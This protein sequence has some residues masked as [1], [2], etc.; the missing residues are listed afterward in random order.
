[1]K[2][3]A[4]CMLLA[5]C[6]LLMH[7]IPLRAEQPPNIVFIISD[8]HAWT[9]YGFMGHPQIETPHLDALAK[10]SAVFTRGYVPTA[11]CRPAL[12][13][14]ITGK[15][16]HQH[17][18]SGNDPAIL[19][20]MR[21]P[22]AQGA[23]PAEYRE[24]RE[25]LIAQIDRQP[26]LPQLLSTRGYR[27]H[28]SGKWWEGNF[29]RGGFTD[30]MTRGFPEPGGRHGDDGLKIGRE[31]MEPVLD[32]IDRCVA[33]NQ[34]FF[35]WYAPFLPHSPHNPPPRLLAK[36]KAKGIESEHVARY[37]AMVE[38]FDETCGQLTEH[39]DAKG[40]REKT[41]IVYIGDNGWIQDP[42]SSG[43]A[44]RSK[45]SANEGGTRQ[46]TMFCWPSVIK[47]GD[48]QQQLCSSV[49]IVP[50]ALAAAGIDIPQE[51]P[52][53]NLL[54]ALKSGEPA[55]REQVF[56]ESFA[57]DIAD[58]DQPEA[59][60]LYRWVIDGKWKLL[61]TYD[62]KVGRYA[63]HHPLTE[64][65]PQLF[66]LL[67]D[68][69][70]DQ[71]LASAEPEVLARLAERLQAWWPV[72]ERKVQTTIASST[73]LNPQRPN[74]LFIA[75]DDQNDWV[76]HMGG[77]PLAHT[78]HIDQLAERGTTFLNAHCQ[79][80]L[81]NPSRTSLM[82]SLR[83]TTTGIY[84]LAP[85]FRS[86]DGWKDRVTLAQHFKRSGYRTLTAGKIFH[87]GVGDPAARRAE[88]DEWGPAGGIGV[89]P[90]QKLI[91]ATPMGN[92]PLMDWG[93]FPHR[94]EDK[95]DYQVASWAVEQI[96]S[97]DRGQPFFLAA[98]FF[99]PHVPCY[100]TQ[101][102]FDL[103]PDDDR[104]LPL[105]QLDDRN[106]TPR[107]SWY[108]HWH[109]PEPRLKWVQDNAQWRNLSRSYLAC[110]SFVDEQ[111]GRVLA[112]LDEAGLAD[113]T[114]VVLWSDHGFHLGEKGITGKN[115]LWED[116]TRVPLVF[117]GPGVSAQ[118]RCVQPAELLD[119]YPTLVELCGLPP[120]DDLEGI[121]LLPQL[122]DA[123]THRE[124]PAVTS[125]NQGNHGVRS[126]RWRYIR[127][128]DGSEELYDQQTDPHEWTNLIANPG[129]AEVV[130][131]HKRWLPVHDVEPAVGSAHRVLTYD[132][133]T[134]EAIWEG[135]AIR[136]DT[137]IP[138]D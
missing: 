91:P 122:Q 65:G 102:W 58:I 2:S 46:P 15:Y 5:V 136:R 44:A 128:A 38:W 78:P 135:Q 31:G 61:L 88:F 124:R 19:P 24:L 20:S 138:N 73:H 41:L 137:P 115:T 71:N 103:F 94:D 109:L 101:K 77:H 120:R 10:Q 40:I 97:A 79:A 83:P 62:G 70:E 68:P 39:L 133:T 69:H 55:P 105:I 6:G 29:R 36:Y 116:G 26:T 43:F 51:L 125:H 67:A 17:K 60:L 4:T 129:L 21:A 74:V 3:V 16:A 106:D 95:G 123:T 76:G 118:Q 12:A 27:S 30:G 45:Q 54:P 1:M 100:T 121:S 32:F 96:R 90:D 47:P 53:Y 52:G 111:V 18:I 82:L 59:S 9:D 99:L 64:K 81:C 107:F 72:T 8:D 85:W 48:R 86:L 113:N 80:P 37:Y 23:E 92:H 130:E 108:L 25:R 33:D 132:K 7:G 14:L 66:D 57:H 134:D 42:G 84:G 127:Y 112:A 35:T 93:V 114:I 117:A 126:E 28:Q 50:T 119:I 131:Q 56:G 49:D 11:L 110:T 104:V 22:A 87:G 13:T 89:K 34:P 63:K 98:G 75:I